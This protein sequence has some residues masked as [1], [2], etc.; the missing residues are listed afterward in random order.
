MVGVDEVDV[1]V[2]D[3]ILVLNVNTWFARLVGRNHLCTLLATM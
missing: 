3:T 2:V 1:E